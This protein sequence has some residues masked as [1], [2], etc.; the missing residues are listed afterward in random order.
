MSS[1]RCLFVTAEKPMRLCGDDS[2]SLC[3]TKVMDRADFCKRYSRK[4]LV[5]RVVM[6]LFGGCLCCNFA[7][8]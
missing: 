4:F 3:M 6:V 5:F 7:E 1:R 2:F 8:E